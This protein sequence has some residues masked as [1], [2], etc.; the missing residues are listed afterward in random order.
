MQK[1]KKKNDLIVRA[2]DFKVQRLES[3]VKNPM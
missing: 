1:N 3:A 2:T